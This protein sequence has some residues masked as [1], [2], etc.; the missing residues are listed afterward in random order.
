MTVHRGWPYSSWLLDSHYC[1]KRKISSSSTSHYCA[2]RC[3]PDD[4]DVHG[5]RDGQ[6]WGYLSWYP[7]TSSFSGVPYSCSTRAPPARCHCDPDDYSIERP[8]HR[9]GFYSHHYLSQRKECQSAGKD[10]G[11]PSH[12]AHLSYCYGSN[13]CLLSGR[14]LALCSSLQINHLA[15][16]LRHNSTFCCWC[17][18]CHWWWVILSVFLCLAW[19]TQNPVPPSLRDA[20]PDQPPASSQELPYTMTK[21][22]TG[23]S[24]CD[25]SRIWRF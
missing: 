14:I 17:T 21:Y 20:W 6:D 23:T 18:L 9:R 22:W 4:Y 11:Y 1:K 5:W 3:P 2:V 24:W 16:D 15:F 8:N 7:L 25:R 10:R 12:S 19:T 13:D